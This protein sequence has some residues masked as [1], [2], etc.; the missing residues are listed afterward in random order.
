MIYKGYHSDAA[1]THGIGEISDTAKNLIDVTR[2]S[3]FE[4]I[5]NAKPGNHLVDIARGIQTC[6]EKA[7]FSVVR[8]LCGHG[9][10]KSLHE[11]PEIPNFVTRRRGTRL[12]KGMTLA[13]EPMINEGSYD[14]WWLEDDWTVVT[15]DGKLAAH[16]ENT[17]VITENGCEILTL[18]PEEQKE[19]AQ[20]GWL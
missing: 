12:Q 16:Y 20:I 13:I 19:L 11:D 4:G 14:V 10:G 17:I 15:I 18:L 1:R 6:A 7:G 3:F 5:K 8:D 9:I 2:Q